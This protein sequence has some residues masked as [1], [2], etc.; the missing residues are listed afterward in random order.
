[1][2][3]DSSSTVNDL[4]SEVQRFCEDR[5][6]D[7]FHNAKDLAIGISTE[8]AELLDNFRFKSNNEIEGLFFKDETREQI[9]QELADVMFFILRFSQVYDIDLAEEL[10][11]KMEINEKKYPVEKARGSNKKYTEL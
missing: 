9:T 8:A 6:W 3:S 1:M 2:P 5:D 11:K 10:T 7:R 4:K